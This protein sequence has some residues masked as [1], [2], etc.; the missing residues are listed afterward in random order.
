MPVKSGASHAVASFLSIIVGSLL[1][2]YLSAH[3]GTLRWVTA[4]VG[5]HL[6]SALGVPVS[7]TLAGI[8]VVATALSFVWGVAYHF[9]RHA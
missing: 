6:G 8:A 4:F 7:N 3:S 1:S 9:S 5:E 2:T